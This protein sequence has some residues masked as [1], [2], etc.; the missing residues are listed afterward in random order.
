M[1]TRY[2][3]QRGGRDRSSWMPS[4]AIGATAVLNG[5]NTGVTYTHVFSPTLVNEAR[6]GYNYLR[7]GNELLQHDTRHK[8]V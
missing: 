4:G 5:A 2:S 1:T 6:A 8:G 7:F 3:Q